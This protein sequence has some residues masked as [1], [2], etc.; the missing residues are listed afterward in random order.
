MSKK[1]RGYANQ[2]ATTAVAPVQFQ[3]RGKRKNN[4]EIEI[5]L[6]WC[7]PLRY[8]SSAQ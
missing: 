4:V 5:L 3:R 2:S 1:I 7:L 6:L 8:P